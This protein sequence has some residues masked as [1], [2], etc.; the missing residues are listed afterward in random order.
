MSDPLT[1]VMLERG[2]QDD[3]WGEQNHNNFYWLGILIEEI[4]ETAEALIEGNHKQMRKELTEACAVALAWLE[5]LERNKQSNLPMTVQSI[6][7]P[8]EK[9]KEAGGEK[10]AQIIIGHLQSGALRPSTRY[11]RVR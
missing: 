8:K 11:P 6:E 1:E 2:R 10:S 9:P 7:N 4:G 5:C 3:K